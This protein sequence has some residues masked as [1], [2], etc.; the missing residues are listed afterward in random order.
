MII[1]PKG[2]RYAKKALKNSDYKVQLGAAILYKNKVISV[3]YNSLRTHPKFANGLNS[4]TIHAEI[5]AILKSKTD[6]EGSSLY[7]Y[8]E[9]QFGPGLAKPCDAC[10]VAIIEAKIRCIYYTISEYPYYE[11][12]KLY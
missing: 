11:K 9:L 8:R 7:V 6:L 2:F 10:L 5:S 1:L 12:I 4:Y 3:G